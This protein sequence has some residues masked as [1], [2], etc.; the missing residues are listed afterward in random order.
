MWWPRLSGPPG[1]HTG[2]GGRP[3]TV[4]DKRVVRALPIT[5][6]LALVV[7]GLLLVATDHWRRGAATFA[8]AATVAAALRLFLPVAR[9]GVLAVRSRAFDVA[10]LLLLAAAFGAAVAQA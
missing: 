3:L 10:F 2:T 7:I 1:E 6:V 8:V 4:A 9:V 5:V